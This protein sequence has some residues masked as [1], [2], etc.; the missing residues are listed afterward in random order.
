MIDI[1]ILNE[2]TAID[3]D[4]GLET[5]IHDLVALAIKEEG[6]DFDGEVSV[7][8][9]D[10]AY[11]HMLNKSHR[12]KDS[13]TDVLSFPQYEN[14]HDI[15]DPYVVLGDIVISTETA[16][17]QAKSFNHP[18]EREIGFLLVHSMFHLMGYDHDTDEATKAMRHKEEKVLTQYQLTR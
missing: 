17:K 18:L 2:Q 11:I 12:D 4:D 9:V 3:I 7:M 10:D 16:I 6:L 8:F 5:I 13:S 1:A 14:V 15:K